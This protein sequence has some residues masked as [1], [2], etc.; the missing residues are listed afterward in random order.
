[1]SKFDEQFKRYVEIGPI[2]AALTNE[3]TE[4]RKSLMVFYEDKN[5]RIPDKQTR[6]FLWLNPD[7]GKYDT[8]VE[9]GRDPAGK[10]IDIG[11]RRMPVMADEASFEEQMR[12][13]SQLGMVENHEKD[14]GHS[15]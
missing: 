3:S 8:L 11:V 5:G 1:M 12:N 4:L 14:S 6:E 9:M 15:P 7:T 10:E 13:D 2:I